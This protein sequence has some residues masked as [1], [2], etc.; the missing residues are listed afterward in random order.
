MRKFANTIPKTQAQ[1][2]RD[3]FPTATINSTANMMGNLIV[4]Q[5]NDTAVIAWIK[6]KGLVEQ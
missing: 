6:N 2:L 3:T 1:E 5:T 4:V